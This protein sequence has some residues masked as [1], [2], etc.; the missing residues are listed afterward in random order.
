MGVVHDADAAILSIRDWLPRAEYRYLSTM[1]QPLSRESYMN[2]WSL[3]VENEEEVL[4]T[5]A[6]RLGIEKGEP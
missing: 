5:L 6:E 3:P 1:A 2:R 4:A